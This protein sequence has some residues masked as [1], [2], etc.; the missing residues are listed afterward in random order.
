MSV[1]ARRRSFGDKLGA[2]LK[3]R[4]MGA[5][6]LAKELSGRYGGSVD[7]RRRTIIR[8]LRGATPVARNRRIVEDVLGMPR[9]SLRGDDEDE[10]EDIA[11]PMTIA[12]SIDY[13]LLAEAIAAREARVEQT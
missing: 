3:A 4:N 2:E 6:T 8:W 9:D 5:R 1:T 11:P 13:D 12:V 10:E 7:V